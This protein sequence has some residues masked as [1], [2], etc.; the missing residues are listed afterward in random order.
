[1]HSIHQHNHR[2]QSPDSKP[3]R[4]RQFRSGAAALEFAIALPLMMLLVILCVDF[5]R[6]AYF[7]TALNNAVGS[8]MTV[9]TTH[10][11]TNYTRQSWEDQIRLAVREDLQSVSSFNPAN[12]QQTI[13]VNESSTR[14]TVVTLTVSYPFRMLI[15]WPGLRQT[16]VLRQTLTATQYR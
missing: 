16:I 11:Y 3:V 10:R 2:R 14:P 7:S 9:A 1:M 8:G 5:G 12:L 6:V 15:N 4:P 13:Q